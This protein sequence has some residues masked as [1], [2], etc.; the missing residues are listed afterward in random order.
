MVSG[1]LKARPRCGTEGTD[2]PVAVRAAAGAIEEP[3][4][5]RR[6]AIEEPWG[7]RRWAIEEP[8]GARCWNDGGGRRMG[9]RRWAI[10]EPW[11]ARRWAIEE[12]FHSALL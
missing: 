11:G 5:A 6:W 4:G 10:E 3:W 12:P 2:G 9:A 7:A 8:W 1:A